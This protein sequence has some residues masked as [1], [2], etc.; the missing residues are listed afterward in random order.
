MIHEIASRVE[1]VVIDNSFVKSKY[2]IDLG[3]FIE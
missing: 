2:S 3:Y 1:V